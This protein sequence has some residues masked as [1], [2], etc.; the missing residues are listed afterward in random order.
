VLGLAAV[1]AWFAAFRYFRGR[2][3]ELSARDKAIGFML[4]G[5]FFGMLHSSLSSRGYRL[6]RRETM[7]LLFIVGVVLT[8]II[9]AIVNAYAGT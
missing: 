9:G 4:A 3:P 5:P 2:P 1:A 8:I 7:G 6:T